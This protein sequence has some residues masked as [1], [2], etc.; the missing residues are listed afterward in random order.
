LL[1][2]LPIGEAEL[3]ISSVA[4]DWQQHVPCNFVAGEIT[5]I[6]AI[7][8]GDCNGTGDSNG[9]GDCTSNS[10]ATA[11]SGRATVALNHGRLRNLVVVSRDTF[12]NHIKVASVCFGNI[13]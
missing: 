1:G 9:T 6:V 12:G 8:D 5:D 10:A 13:L 7:L 4:L 11:A 2:G 3:C